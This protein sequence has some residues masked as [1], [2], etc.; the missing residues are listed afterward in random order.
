MTTLTTSQITRIAKLQL[1]AMGFYCWR[2]NQVAV[3]G[4]KFVGEPGCSDILG[5][6]RKT[7]QFLACEVKGPGDS[8]SDDQEEFLLKVADAGGKAVVACEGDGGNAELVEIRK[9]LE[10]NKRKIK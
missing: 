7:G 4:R 3:R 6:H 5:Y 8:L 1:A 9:Y 2:H 10:I